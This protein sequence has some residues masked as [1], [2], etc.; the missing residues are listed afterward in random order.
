MVVSHEKR[1]I[2]FIVLIRL[3]LFALEMEIVQEVVESYHN[4]Q[5][6]H[7]APLPLG[8]IRFVNS[9]QYAFDHVAQHYWSQAA[10]S[11]RLG[12]EMREVQ[13]GG[14]FNVR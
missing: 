6:P 10:D 7:K 2:F 12:T 5:Y 3:W 1:K 11:T 14:M 13:D 8:S 4:L 9:F